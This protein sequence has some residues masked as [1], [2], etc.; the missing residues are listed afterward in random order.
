MEEIKPRPSMDGQS[1]C[2]FSG[3]VL[4][5]QRA[6]PVRV[7]KNDPHRQHAPPSGIPRL[8]VVDGK[9]VYKEKL[10]PNPFEPHSGRAV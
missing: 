5:E 10:G 1:R 6:E 2:P 7:P 4:G 8:Y 3:V 9:T